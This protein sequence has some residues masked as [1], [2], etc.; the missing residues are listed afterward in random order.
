ME[1][2]QRIVVR[3]L[4]SRLG[5]SAAELIK[6]LMRQNV[7]ATITQEI[8]FEVAAAVAER[9]G[10][11][12]QRPKSSE[13]R[14]LEELQQAA[15]QPA[16]LV[17]RPPVVTIMGHVDHG[18]TTLLDVIRQTRVAAQEYGGIT[19]HIGAYQVETQGRLITFLDT[20]GHEAFTAMRAR[21][22]QVTDIAVLVVAADDGVMPQTIEAINHARAAEVPIIVAINKID[23]PTA[24]PDRVKQ[25]LSEHGLVPEEWG[26]ET[27]MVPV[28]ALRK[29]GIDE[30][31]EMILLVA[32]LRELRA[33][34]DRP[35]SGIV[36]EAQLDRGRGPVATVLIK[37]G[38]LKVG[39]PVIVGAVPGRVRALMDDK[40][41][42][43]QEAGPSTPIVVLGLQDVPQPGDLLM[44][45]PDE[46][47]ARRIA[48]ERAQRQRA[49][50]LRPT[51]RMTLESLSRMAAE[52]EARDLH[53]VLKADV[54]G[55]LEALQQA[56]EQLSG[57][58]VRV[59]V[60]HAAVGAISEA[61]V[62]LAASSGAVIIGF[63]VR[64][65][66]NAR[67]AAE[68]EQIDVRTYRIIYEVVDDVKAAM[69]GLLKP[70]IEERV[71]GRAEVRRT[72]KVP[73]VGVVA[74]CYVVE[75]RANR[76]ASV[77]VLRD[78]VVVHEGKIA[79]LKR[80]KEDV[81]EVASGY[82][83]GIGIDR[84]ND[85]KEGDVLEFYEL[86]EVSPAAQVTA[87]NR[88]GA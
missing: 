32:D 47:T 73:G 52:G 72:F 4:A 61:D 16:Q 65:D 85:V 77:R 59:N 46:E 51:A 43:R 7:M 3:D 55:S 26:G 33:P 42:Q 5:V 35:A 62:N 79:S 49:E 17:P 37:E 9:F 64:P 56:L 2:P 30:L 20:P 28:S 71:L 19:Q 40:G 48:E 50:Q 75:G 81:R 69:Q 39:D 53:I 24:N 54:Q 36:V 88:G 11:T 1:L 31:L 66:A 6:Q 13:E 38:V 67:R 70:R 84:F 83:C 45:T 41:Q 76:N 87:G 23:K 68:R 29:E 82:E 57:D 21:G 14:F 78:N 86:A 80:F 10:F 12:V 22:A 25:Q 34:V 58:Q 8:P 44:V 63:N 27:V 60:I 74:G 18:K 15:R